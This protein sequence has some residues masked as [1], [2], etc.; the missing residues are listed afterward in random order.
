MLYKG[1]VHPL[2]LSVSVPSSILVPREEGIWKSLRLPE[3]QVAFGPKHW[4]RRWGRPTN[5]ILMLIIAFFQSWSLISLHLREFTQVNQCVFLCFH[6]G[7]FVSYCGCVRVHVYTYA[8]IHTCTLKAHQYWRVHPHPRPTHTIPASILHP[9]LPLAF[10]AQTTGTGPADGS[11]NGFVTPRATGTVPHI[12]V[13]VVLASDGSRYEG[14]WHQLR[15]PGEAVLQ[16]A[17]ASA[18][19]DT[20]CDASSVKEVRL[21]SRTWWNFKSQ[22]ATHYTTRL[23]ISNDIFTWLLKGHKHAYRADFWDILPGSH[24]RVNVYN[25][26]SADFWMYRAHIWRRRS[27]CYLSSIF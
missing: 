17:F 1:R 18:S 14:D 22:L 3:F 6:Q 15:H 20:C 10:F 13:S 19:R 23:W 7:Q 9:A 26:C 24:S 21:R 5:Y 16:H 8:P 12:G 25:D 2:P 27:T 11:G 4:S